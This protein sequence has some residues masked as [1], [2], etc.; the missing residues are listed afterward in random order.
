MAV[1]SKKEFWRKALD[2][3]IDDRWYEVSNL[4][5]YYAGIYKPRDFQQDELKLFFSAYNGD[6]ETLKNV[7]Q[8]EDKNLDVFWIK[9][10]IFLAS[11]SGELEAVKLLHQHCGDLHSKSIILAVEAGN[12]DVVQYLFENIDQRYLAQDELLFIASVHNH[13]PI[14]EYF[15]QQGFNLSPKG[16]A[17][18]SF[19]SAAHNGNYKILKFLHEKG[20]DFEREGAGAMCNA[21]AEGHLDIVRYLHRNGARLDAYESYVLR[22][23]AE[24]GHLPVIKYLTEQGIDIHMKEEHA[25]YLA[26]EYG[27]FETIKYLH[28]QGAD[29]EAHNNLALRAVLNT[30]YYHENQ[31]KVLEYFFKNGFDEAI[32]D[33]YSSEK[34]TL[35]EF[36]EKEKKII[37]LKEQSSKEYNLIKKQNNKTLEFFRLAREE[38]GRTGFMV[39]AQAGQ[40]DDIIKLSMSVKGGK[41]NSHDLLQKDKSEKSVLSYLI[42]DDKVDLILAPSL[43]VGHKKEF[44][45]LWGE[46]P[47]N[48]KKTR[49]LPD[50]LRKI[51]RETLNLRGRHRNHSKR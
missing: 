24:S 31:G 11:Q 38:D 8:R 18:S 25:L 32:L 23:A 16:N 9:S 17:F 48:I 6:V 41:L 49:Y 51:D 19:K 30:S 21:A 20:V 7:L 2:A 37:R 35:S 14:V 43:W 45:K 50:C 12:L 10:S 4:F 39:A 36:R 42:E 27:H 47:D 1:L 40:F 33:D 5:P 44:I 28:E 13:F 15:Q 29:L 3:S 26:A 46:L 22:A 34:K